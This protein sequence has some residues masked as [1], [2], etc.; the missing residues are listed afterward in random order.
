MLYKRASYEVR[1]HRDKRMILQKMLRGADAN[2]AIQ[3]PVGVKGLTSVSSPLENLSN[4]ANWP[5]HLTSR[6][7]RVRS[8]G[9]ENWLL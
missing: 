6:A 8:K 1:K 3:Y 7:A 5:N 9:M 4:F 2:A